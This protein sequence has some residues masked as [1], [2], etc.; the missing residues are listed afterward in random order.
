MRSVPGSHKFERTEDLE[1]GNGILLTTLYPNDHIYTNTTKRNV[2][3]K[4]TIELLTDICPFDGLPCWQQVFETLTTNC[5]V[6]QC[7][8]MSKYDTETKRKCPALVALE[9]V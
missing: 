2:R 7:F 6:L 9:A 4:I 5:L 1:P 3:V 8:D